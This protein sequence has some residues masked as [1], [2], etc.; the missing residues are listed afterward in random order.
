M[1][2]YSEFIISLC[3]FFG[4]LVGPTF[5]GDFYQWTDEGGT[6][7]FAESPGDVPP[8][9]RDQIKSGTFKEG[10]RPEETKPP[11]GVPGAQ[12]R[13]ADVPVKERGVRRYE[14]PYT[15]YEGTSRR[16]IVSATLNGSVAARMAIDT[17][18]PGMILS[19]RLAEKLGL[20]G[21]DQAR[22]IVVA[23]GVGGSVPAIRTIVDSID[24]GGAKDR[25]VPT[26][27]V[28][29]IS[30]AFEGLIGMDFMS[31]YS[32]QIDSKKMVVVFQ[33][34]APGPDLP[35][36]HDE[37]WWRTLF[38]EFASS[39]ADWKEYRE[40]LDKQIGESHITIGNDDAH[41]RA[42]ADFQYK[43]ADKLLDKLNRYAAENVVPTNWREY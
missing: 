43:Q 39:R 32:M 37:T 15:S 29:S 7:H 27:V 5:A 26:T 10:G 24:V 42:F 30:D 25:F 36:G 33:E 11:D 38:N 14:M 13:P 34:I 19:P 2:R 4:F 6:V 1:R 12:K 23:R 9:Y 8:K 20:F 35:G 3:V 18:S 17:G 28:E 41:L 22:L 21:K 16:I 31:H 40:L